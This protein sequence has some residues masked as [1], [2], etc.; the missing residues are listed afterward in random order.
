MSK[1]LVIVESPAKARTIRKYLGP[2]Y[3]V[4][5]SLGHVK[6]LPKSKMGVAVD[7]SFAPEYQV[8]PGK[9]KVLK[10]LIKSAEA[11]DRIFL[12]LDPDREGEAIAWHIAEELGVSESRL[13]RVLFNEITRKGIAEGLDNPLPLNNRRF[14]SQQARRIL[15]RLVGYELSPILWKKVRRGLSAGRVQSVALRLVVDREHEIDAF[16]PREYWKIGAELAGPVP[17]QFAARYWGTDGK[18]N[19]VGDEATALSIKADLEASSFTVSSV[20]RK[21]RKRAA[22]PPLITSRLQQ[23]MARRFRYT[24]KRTMMV[25]QQLY[26]GVDVGSEGTVGLITYMRTDS[27][28]L[29]T[30]AVDEARAYI[31]EV[32]GEDAVPSKPNVFKSRKGAQDAHEAIRPT[33]VRYL[34]DAVGKYLSPDQRK[35]YRVV[36]ERFVAC[37]MKPAVYDQTAV[38]VEAGRHTLRVSGSVLKSRGWLEATDDQAAA[39]G[40]NGDADAEEEVADLPALSEGVM[41]SLTSAGVTPEQKFTQAPPR[42]TE[43][44]LI[45]ELEERGIGRPSTYATILS[46]ILERRYVVK[47]EGRLKPSELGDLVTDRLVR[48]F[49][50][51]LDADFTA[52]MEESLDK[53]EDG[54]QDWV[55]LLT[56]FYKPFHAEVQAALKKMEDVRDMRVE[57]SE[58]C[59]LCGKP[60]VV[61]WGRNGRFLACTGF[62]A[63]RSTREMEGGAPSAPLEPVD[64]VC[65][66]CGK[67]MVR[68]HGR[69]GD[70]LACS[71]YPECKATRSV[72]TG[73]ACPKPGCKGEL[74]ERRTKTGRVFF[75][76]S[77]YKASGC[78]FVVW[79]TPVKESCPDC[80]AGFLVAAN[81]RRTGREL[82]CTAAGCS[83]K[84]AENTEG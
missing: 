74:V 75:G 29:S 13:S 46:T 51:I 38:T 36:W 84:R 32:F 1:S 52:S 83:F 80:G 21:E 37:Q 55:V 39:N 40:K 53:I 12:A 30:D 17:P 71:G 73:I 69:F 59:E 49:P 9:R 64:V 68:K 60:M 66:E 79:G 33:S 61:K 77:E 2:S 78:D 62:P 18:K 54:S 6:D 63:C 48:H 11:A 47:D 22:P 34:P 42:F 45:R 28:R 3:V 81:Q 31:R 43:G 24:A 15:D 58:V 25:A 7:N 56:E 20:D 16:V 19:D 67:P 72:P 8:I 26:E 14:E 82:K 27:V 57:S 4:K 10:D 35:L 76:C 41:L 5:A 23:E 65:S 70:F 44:T 50:R